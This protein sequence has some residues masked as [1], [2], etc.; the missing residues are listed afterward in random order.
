MR[1]NVLRS[2]FVFRAVLVAALGGLIVSFSACGGAMPGTAMPVTPAVQG[3]V[4]GGQPPIIGASIDLYAVT[5]TGYATAATAILPAPVM[6]N[7]YGDFSFAGYTCPSPTSLTYL[8]ATGGN[9][10]L[11]GNNNN[12]AIALMALVGE[13]G[14][15]STS[16]FIDMDE[17]TTVASVYGLAPFMTF[18]HGG[19]W[20]ATSSTNAQGLGNAFSLVSNL[21]VNTGRGA[22]TAPGPSVP[23]GATV[24]TAEINSLADIISGCINSTDSGSTA[25]TQLFSA[26]T[27]NSAVP[28]N[29][30]DAVLAIAQN[31]AANP[32]GI[33]GLMPTGLG[34]VYSPTLGG[35]PADWTMPITYTGGLSQPQ[36]IA[37]DGSGNIW[38]A[39]TADSN[40]MEYSPYG[41]L[42][43]GAPYAPAGGGWDYPWAIAIDASGNAWVANTGAS[44]II[45]LTSSGGL[46]TNTP[47]GDGG[48]DGVQD[49]AIAV[50]GSGD[51]WTVK[52]TSPYCCSNNS[53]V[54]EF[55][56]VNTAATGSPFTAGEIPFSSPFSI[57]MDH[58]GNAWLA[59]YAG[60]FCCGSVTKLTGGATPTATSYLNGGA[61]FANPQGIAIGASGTVWTA[62]GAASLTALNLSDG[63]AVT[64]SPY[65]AT[66]LNNPQG[67]AI[68][69]LGNVWVTNA[70]GNT[71]SEF[72]TAGAAI[73][74]DA[75]NGYGSGAG[76]SEPW[77][78]AIDGSGNAWVTSAAGNT[79]T[80]FVGI[81][82]PTVTPLATQA[83][84]N[85]F[86]TLP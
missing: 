64:G 13:C 8:V 49:I 19:T 47:Y 35:Q 37:A 4:H 26:T 53:S 24:P 12:T 70:D 31:P 83:A 74:P 73:S 52:D 17:V 66:Q 78:I 79:V 63:S 21:L 30:I 40:V 29:T 85:T 75:T 23:S 58:S 6:T 22:G 14:S 11:G 76:L 68:D 25:C 36:G 10:S 65:T 33:W 16:T 27:V 62:N 41:G 54:S 57:A 82:A 3:R 60:G 44:T 51:L 55:T 56:A 81:A 42:V 43:A 77:A 59:D 34:I 45:G 7:Q 20:V 38:V 86:G 5:G 1:Q 71:I 84:N 2:V 32:S 28:T 69:G 48:V 72:S 39:N 61:D 18:G 80:E 67:I 46:I 15:I 50:D 9:P